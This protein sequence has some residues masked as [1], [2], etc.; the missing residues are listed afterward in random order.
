MGFLEEIV[1]ETRRSLS[2]PAYGAGVPANPPSVRPSL[3]RA[4]ARDREQGALVV[5]YKRV[6]PGQPDPVL[7]SRSVRQFVD[8]TRAAAPTAF[9]CLATAARFDGA[10]ADV[11]E[12]AGST[13]RPV[14]FKDFVIDRRQVEVA[15]RTGASAILLIARLERE[16]HL[17]EPLSFLANEAHRLGLEVLL[18]FHT[19]AELSCGAG[20]A[21][22]VYGVNARNL[23][24]LE[25]D[26]ASAIETVREAR[27]QW[28]RPLLGLSGVEQASDALGFWEAGVDGILVGSAVARAPDPVAFL[29]TLRRPSAGEHR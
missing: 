8:S 18:E 9:S 15:A 20:V 6:S 1:R 10:P 11:A 28:L 25:I 23:D 2:D 13:D 17:T 7:P 19:R 5:E 22:D 3:H 16:G 27:G 21:A 29:A 26:R 24:T 4:L 12:L 14:L